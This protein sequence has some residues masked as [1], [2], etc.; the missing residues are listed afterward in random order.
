MV[1][2][3]LGIGPMHELCMLMSPTRAAG[4]PPIITVAE[5]FDTIAGPAGTQPAAMHGM[6]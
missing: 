5:A 6:L 1:P 3:G 4:I 2:V